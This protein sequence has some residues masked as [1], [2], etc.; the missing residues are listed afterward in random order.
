MTRPVSLI[1]GASRGIGR[2]IAIQLA[3][4][5]YQVVINYRTNQ[6]LA[7]AVRDLI[8]HEGG[9]AMVRGFDVTKQEE[10]EH[11]V[12]DIT[13]TVGPIQV[14]V[15][16]AATSSFHLLM[17][18]PDEDW[19]RIIDT[20]LNGVY[21]CTKAVVRTMAGTRRP[22]RRIITMSSIAGEEGYAGSTHYCAAKAA[23][24]G[25]TKALAREL[26]PMDVTVNAIAPGFIETNDTL[27]LLPIE[28]WVKKI[29]LGRIG[30]PDEVAHLVSF[31]VSERASYITGQVIRVNGGM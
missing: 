1:T 19:H 18:M 6:K 4:D 7:E 29:P 23:V 21:Y 8:Q 14:L 20:D 10:V 28:E 15:N 2:A 26:A 30:Q 16:N 25:F 9:R 12:N 22:G 11:A 24:I 5:G 27:R 17:R 13:R 31:L 3:N